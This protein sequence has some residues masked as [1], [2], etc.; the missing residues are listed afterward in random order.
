MSQDANTVGALE[1]AHACY[2][3]SR[4]GA[5]FSQFFRDFLEVFNVQSHWDNNNNKMFIQGIHRDP[6]SPKVSVHRNFR[7]FFNWLM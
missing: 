4:A 2:G 6:P 1:N 3:S 7:S 5:T